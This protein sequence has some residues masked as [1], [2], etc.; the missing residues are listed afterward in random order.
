MP[1][2]TV[3]G[4]IHRRHAAAFSL[5]LHQAEDK[6]PPDGDAVDEKNLDR[7]RKRTHCE[8]CGFFQ[9]RGSSAQDQADVGVAGKTA[10]VKNE[11][12]RVGAET[13]SQDCQDSIS[14]TEGQDCQDSISW[15]RVVQ[16][17]ELDGDD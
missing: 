8:C 10:V 15:G 14:L 16:D 12:S 3:H 2:A 11:I 13:E 17:L 4:S 7:E 1:T 9:G 5:V 6:V